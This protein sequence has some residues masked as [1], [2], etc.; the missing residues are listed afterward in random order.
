MVRNIG[1][2]VPPPKRECNDPKCPFHGN[3][4]IRGRIFEG[5]IVSTKMRNTVV[6]R[7]DYL[8]YLKK[9]KRY[10]KRHGTISAHLPQ[11]FE[12][13]EVGDIVKIAECRPLSKTISYVVV[14]IK[15]KE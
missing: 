2:G 1:I 3:L 10:E 13:I 9:Y 6:V 5:K 14:Q 4:S 7:R 12:N 11:C 8:H 15:S